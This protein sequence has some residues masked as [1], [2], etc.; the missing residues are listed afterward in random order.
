[1]Q[2]YEVLDHPMVLELIRFLHAQRTLVNVVAA[3]GYE[4]LTVITDFTSGASRPVFVI[5]PPSGLREAIKEQPAAALEFEFTGDDRLKHQFDARLI[6]DDGQRLHFAIPDHIRRYQMRSNFRI[7]TPHGAELLV[8]LQE[9]H[10]SMA[11]ENISISG[12]LCCCSNSHKELV[13]SHPFVEN[14]QLVFTFHFHCTMVPVAQAEM[15]RLESE[16]RLK[17]FSVAYHF[18]QIKNEARQLLRHQIYEM[19]REYLQNRLRRV[20]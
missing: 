14:V 16:A 9:R 17:K 10:V 19:Q 7:T 12:V 8:T 1:M 3:G 11:I 18:I 15:R 2:D 5:D 13:E 4:R 20:E 6:R